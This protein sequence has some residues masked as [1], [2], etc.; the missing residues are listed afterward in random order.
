MFSCELCDISKN[1]FFTEHLWAT[2]SVLIDEEKIG[3]YF[4]VKSSLRTVDQHYTGKFLVQV[5]F[6]QIKTTLLWLFSCK[7]MTISRTSR[8]QMLLQKTSGGCFDMW[9]G[10]SLH[11]QISCAMWSQPYSANIV[12]SSRLHMFFKISL[13][14]NFSDFTL[15]HLWW[16]FFLIKLQ[17]WRLAILLK[18]NSNTGVFLSILRSF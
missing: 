10:P 17:L 6:R 15:K 8:S 3:K 11:Q 14:E 7:K 4:S 1:T 18:R 12:R 16:S 2:S 5:W 13:L 9:S